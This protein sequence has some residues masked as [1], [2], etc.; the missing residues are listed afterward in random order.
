MEIWLNQ[1][2]QEIC[3]PVIPP[4]YE[5][6]QSMNNTSVNIVEFG[7]VNMIGKRNLFTTSITS[8][9]PHEKYNF[10]EVSD[11]LSPI[12]YVALINKMKSSPV[13]FIISDL[14]LNLDVTIEQFNYSQNDATGD[15]NYTLEL[16]EYRK[17][18]TKK[19]KTPKPTKSSKGKDKSKNITKIQV[20]RGCKLVKSTTYR[21]K[22]GDTLPKIAKNLTGL[23][24]NARAIANQNKISCL[25][26]IKKWVGKKLV[27]KV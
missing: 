20:A 2:E 18:A 14:K 19:M 8:F 26:D 21:V 6:S 25:K 11:I 12:D 17:P 27:I 1:G 15:I 13:K 23:S 10:V 4:Q 22:K 9:F 5:I 7:E 3:L 24:K 16:K